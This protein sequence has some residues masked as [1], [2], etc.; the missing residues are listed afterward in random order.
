MNVEA[1][2]WIARS[3]IIGVGIGSGGGVVGGEVRARVLVGSMS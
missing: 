2:S 3:F 1:R